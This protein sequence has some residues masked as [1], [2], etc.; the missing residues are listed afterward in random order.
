MIQRKQTVFLALGALL[1]GLLFALP[2]ARYARPG[3]E[4]FD[5]RLTGLYDGSGTAVTDVALKFPMHVLAG[6]LIALLVVVIVLFKDR[7][8]QLRLVRFGYVFAMGLLASAFITHTSVKAYL[9]LGASVEASLLPG[10]FVPLVVMVC[11]F[12]AERGIK[13]D[14]ELVKSMDRLR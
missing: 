11:C 5:L 13:A 1:T 7:P 10:F 6:L 9:G 3:G 14:E 4:A 8:R 12:L 2:L